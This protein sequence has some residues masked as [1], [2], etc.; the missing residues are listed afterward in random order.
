MRRMRRTKRPAMPP[1]T[2]IQCSLIHAHA[3]AADRPLSQSPKSSRNVFS[4]TVM[5]SPDTSQ[6]PL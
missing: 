4:L 5:H 6:Y 2:Y 3:F 1:T